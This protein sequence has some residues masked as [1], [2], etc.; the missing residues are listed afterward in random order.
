[1]SLLKKQALWRAL[2][3]LYLMALLVFVVLKFDGSVSSITNRIALYHLWEDDYGFRPLNFIPFWTIR[4]QL[5][6]HGSLSILNLVAN[7]AAFLPLGMLLP[8]A[9]HKTD[10]IGR[11]LLLSMG[12]S[13]A[14]ELFQ[15]VT[16]TGSC[17]IDDV[18]LNTLGALLGYGLFKWWSGAY[19]SQP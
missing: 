1:M 11:T 17:D 5:R 19:E 6:D 10:T 3:F 12:L 4:M 8:C 2:F 9:F 14:I 16:Y 7:V 18:L 15:L 13:I